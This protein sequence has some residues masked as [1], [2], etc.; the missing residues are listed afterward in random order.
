MYRQEN[1]HCFVCGAH[2]TCCVC[3]DLCTGNAFEKRLDKYRVNNF[4][5]RASLYRHASV[6]GTKC[7]SYVHVLE[8]AVNS[9]RC[10][11][12]VVTR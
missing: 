11:M 5:F 9:Q 3:I 8:F 4:A 1:S 12:H 6:K 7:N 10:N 2:T